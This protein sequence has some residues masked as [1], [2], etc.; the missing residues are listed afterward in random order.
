MDDSYTERNSVYKAA[1]NVRF[2]F[3]KSNTLDA[4]KTPQGDCDPNGQSQYIIKSGHDLRGIRGEG[5][6]A[7]LDVKTYCHL[8]SDFDCVQRNSR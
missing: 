2:C 6:V 4:E 7:L 3:T 5:K 8:H 1:A